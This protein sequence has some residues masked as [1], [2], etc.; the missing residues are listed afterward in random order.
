[1]L[2][3]SLLNVVFYVISSS[4]P[5]IINDIGPQCSVIPHKSFAQLIAVRLIKRKTNNFLKTNLF[6]LESIR[7]LITTWDTKN[8]R[9]EV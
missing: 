8:V 3:N 9:E 2:D 1:M 4:A 7:E 6:L 5:L